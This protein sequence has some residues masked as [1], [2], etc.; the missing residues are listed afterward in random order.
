MSM[1][2][3]IAS[4][5]TKIRNAC[6]A[7]HSVVDIPYSKLKENIAEV[8]S[9]ENFITDFKAVE[10]AN[11]KSIRIYLRYT[12]EHMS[13]IQGIHRVSRPGLRKYVPVS[14]IPRILGGLG[15]AIMSTPKGVMTNKKARL[16]HVGGEILCKVW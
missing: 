1:T 13:V 2:D 3:P 4:M 12:D 10:H 11:M 6:R 8:L 14:E 9:Y 15:I 7:K 16:N 5:L